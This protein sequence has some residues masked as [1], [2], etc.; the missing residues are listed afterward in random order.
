MGYFTVIYQN[1]DG[2]R[3]KDKRCFVGTGDGS[4]NNRTYRNGGES[5]PVPADTYHVEGWQGEYDIVVFEVKEGENTEV[6]LRA[7]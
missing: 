2:T 4:K 1:A 3:A 5:Y 6:I 7:K